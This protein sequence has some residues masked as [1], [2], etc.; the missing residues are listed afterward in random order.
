MELEL[1]KPYTSE[2]IARNIFNV[3][4]KTFSNKRQMYLERLSQVYEWKIEKRKYILIAKIGDG[5]LQRQS[6]MEIQQEI[7][8][9]VHEVVNQYPLQTYVS[10]ARLMQ[11]QNV[12]YV[13]RHPQQEDTMVKYIR[14]VME[15]DYAIREWV[16]GD[17]TQTPILPLTEDQREYLMILINKRK[18]VSLD[19]LAFSIKAAEDSGYISR[20]EAKDLLYGT[21]TNDYEDVMNA[22][23][24]KY[25]FRPRLVACWQEGIAF[26]APYILPYGNKK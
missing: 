2:E 11:L 22:F 4:G 25:H 16:W 17:V 6:K 7:R 8:N 21:V 24:T 12:P 10:I 18:G 13:R 20:E 14:P 15:T 3:S 26:D 23:K 19:E 5:N 9:P 1:N